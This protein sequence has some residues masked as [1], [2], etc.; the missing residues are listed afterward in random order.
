MNS[1]LS[2]QRTCPPRRPSGGGDGLQSRC[3]RRQSGLHGGAARRET[4]S[5]KNELSHGDATQREYNQR[6]AGRMT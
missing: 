2:Q 3:M 6:N 1:R 4:A 5:S